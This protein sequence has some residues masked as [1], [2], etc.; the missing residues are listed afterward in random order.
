MSSTYIRA[1]LEAGK[2]ED[3]A[4]LLGRPYSITAPV[5]HGKKLGRT[6]GIPTINQEFPDGSVR[7]KEGIYA[8]VCELGG[9][10]FFGVVN[11]GRRPMV[12]DNGGLNCE[13]YIID[14]DREV[15]GER[16]KLSFYRRLRDEKRFSS[17]DELS[18]AVLENAKEA[19][20]YFE[21]LNK[22][23]TDK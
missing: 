16:V 11:V 9:E 13:T 2:T 21:N 20:A 4:V 18:A 8:C 23:G 12:E 14:F 19:K 7:V 3:A 17:L 1:L 22:G 6:I 5:L 10:R 15:Y